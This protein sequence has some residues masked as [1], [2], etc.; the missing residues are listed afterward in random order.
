M[1]VRLKRRLTGAAVLVLLAVIFLPMLFE[2]GLREKLGF[3]PPIESPMPALIPSQKPLPSA[4]VVKV[5]SLTDR[6]SAQILQDRLRQA[7]F[8]AFV[9]EADDGRYRVGV[10]PMLDQKQA[11]AEV[12]EIKQRLNL[13]ASIVS[14]PE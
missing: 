12:A 11:E 7:G 1:D 4:W 9:D 6:Q 3:D 8:A 13:D 14:Y 5:G 10:G 2:K